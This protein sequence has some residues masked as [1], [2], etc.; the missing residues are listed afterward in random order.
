MCSCGPTGAAPLVLTYYPYPYSYSYSYP[1]PHPTTSARAD[2][3]PHNNQ[4]RT[5][6]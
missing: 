5:P 6:E 2:H 4:T 1:Y 3:Y